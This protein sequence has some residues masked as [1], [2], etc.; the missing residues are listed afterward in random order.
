MLTMTDLFCGA[1][2]STSGA[3]R[4]PGV[5]VRMA[6][7][8]SRIAIATHNAN[9]P[10]TDHDCVNI[11]QSDPRRYPRTDLLWGSAE[12]THHTRASG[13]KR[14]HG[15][16]SDGLF[17]TDGT[18]E[19]AIRS[20]ATMWDIPR[21]AEAH[22]YR[23]IVTENVVDA[24][25]WGPD[26]APGAAFDSWVRA[27]RTWGYEHTVVYLD[28]A[29]AQATGPGSRSRRPRM[30]VLF[31]KT[32]ER[33]P[34]LNKWL[35]PRGECPT[36][37]RVSL[38]QAWKRTS[39][40]SPEHP[41]GVYGIKTGQYVYRCPN[42]S[43]R[44]RIV[45][46]T[47]RSAAEAIDWG[48]PAQTIGGRHRPL[49]PNTM[50]KIRA[51]WDA[52]R[53]AML[54]PCGGSWNDTA[55]PVDRLMRTRTATESE[56]V[57]IPPYMIELHG[58]GSSHRPVTEP[59]STVTAGGINHGL[60]FADHELLPY[61]GTS[62][63]VPVTRPAPTITTRDRHGL[64]GYAAS[65]ED[66]HYRMLSVRENANA[67]EFPDSYQFLGERDENI[68]MIGNAVTPNAAQD[69]VAMMTEAVTGEDLEPAA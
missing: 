25:W 19:A 3:T 37:G 40:C 26:S 53:Q 41:W 9:H 15:E 29:H 33:A 60:V 52:Y 59:L 2:G 22:D 45:E 49:V 16:F 62:A 10:N 54:V 23:A 13:K 50:R 65:L 38:L 67:M 51:G 64:V 21:F 12:C 42:T 17:A 27:V 14:G 63:T 24:R 46:P 30:Y 31:W 47:V 61:Y 8:H 43:C 7:N 57:V 35:R 34:D 6:L 1:G 28:S 68:A 69:L 48:L 36:C 11:S 44:G 66:C 5:R 58:G 56:A 55:Y 39:M 32:G 4:I 20:R 18:D